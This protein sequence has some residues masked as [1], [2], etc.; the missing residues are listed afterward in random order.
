[1]TRDET[2]TDACQKCG[3]LNIHIT[4]DQESHDKDCSWIWCGKK[5]PPNQWMAFE[6]SFLVTIINNQDFVPGSDFQLMI[7]QESGRA[8]FR[9]LK[10]P[11]LAMH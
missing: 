9:D 3:T 1:M 11:S 7:V 2:Y 6:L 4:I 10:L 5:R 8:V